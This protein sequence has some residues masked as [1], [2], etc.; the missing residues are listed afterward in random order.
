MH[1]SWLASLSCARL[2]GLTIDTCKPAV[3]LD[4]KL[5]AASCDHPQLPP[6]A[7]ALLQH[8]LRCAYQAGLIWGQANL[9]N[10]NIPSPEGWGWQKDDKGQ[11]VPVWT[12]IPAIWDA[13][14]QYLVKC[15]C[16]KGCTKLCSC[17]KAGKGVYCT[18]FCT[19]CRGEC[20]NKQPVGVSD[21]YSYVTINS[22]KE[23]LSLNLNSFV[24]NYV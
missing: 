9:K 13:C 23:S 3:S 1:A 21:R 4:P 18:V 20:S 22:S 14:R 5:S 24:T 8:I 17:R 2:A 7:N 6:R 16:K 19:A 11:W 12:T 10:P 15:G